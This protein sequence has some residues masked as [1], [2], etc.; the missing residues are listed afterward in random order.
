MRS[1]PKNIQLFKDLPHQF[2]WS[3]VSHS[4]LNSLRGCWT[5]TAIAAKSSISIV[6]DGKCLCCSVIHNA[7]GKHQ[8]VVDKFIIGNSNGPIWKNTKTWELVF[9][10]GARK[11][12]K[13]SLCD[14]IKYGR[15]EKIYFQ[16]FLGKR[17]KG[18]LI[19]RRKKDKHTLLVFPYKFLHFK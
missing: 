5:L 7:L 17:K 4:T 11:S 14:C 19:K 13:L 1:V 8:F 6:A 12:C 2:S 16:P 15:N 9:A 10:L 18:N 3:T